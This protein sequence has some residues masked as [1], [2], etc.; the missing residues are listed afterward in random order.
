MPTSEPFPAVMRRAIMAARARGQR[1]C[2]PPE[3]RLRG[4]KVN[5][6]A[7][8]LDAHER[9]TQELSDLHTAKAEQYVNT[10]VGL[11]SMHA[12]DGAVV[13]DLRMAREFTAAWVAAAV[14]MLADAE[15]YAET[16]VDYDTGRADPPGLEIETGHAGQERYVLRVQRA[17][18]LTP[19]EAREAAEAERDQLRAELAAYRDNDD[20]H[21][22]ASRP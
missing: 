19:H 21:P 17:G 12:E 22:E 15:N 20:P 13:M 5:Q 16:R 14:A 18:R 1:S 9:L 11:R 2:S 8:F 6:L 7:A 4:D 10:A 3:I